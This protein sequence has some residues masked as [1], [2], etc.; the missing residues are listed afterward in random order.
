MIMKGEKFFHRAFCPCSLY[1]TGANL[2]CQE[3]ADFPP[4]LT[5]SEL[6]FTPFSVTRFAMHRIYADHINPQPRRG[7]TCFS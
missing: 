7:L 6:L 3:Q 4:V 1:I 5:V 2:Q